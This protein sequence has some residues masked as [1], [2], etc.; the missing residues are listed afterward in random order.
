[1][2]TVNGSSGQDFTVMILSGRL[3]VDGSSVPQPSQTLPS[4][5]RF[6]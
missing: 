5:I 4:T 6:F 1:M 2:N 3:R